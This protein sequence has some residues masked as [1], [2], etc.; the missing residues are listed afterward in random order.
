ML[1]SDGDGIYDTIEI[2]GVRIQ[3]GKVVY[4]DP[5]KADTDG[6]GVS[7]FD[8]LGGLPYN[9]IVQW[10]S[11]E[12]VSTI[13]YQSSN[14][15]IFELNTEE[16]ID[17]YK[18][19]NNFE[20]LPYAKDNYDE[21]FI[22]DTGKKNLRGESIYGLCNI[23][24]SNPNELM[25]IRADE[26]VTKV[27]IQELLMHNGKVDIMKDASNFLIRYVLKQ[28]ERNFYDSKEILRSSDIARDI[29][30]LDVYYLMLAAEK[31]LKKDQ[32]VIFSTI[33]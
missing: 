19:V 6:D 15:N 24:N 8:E 1:D 27:I 16:T 29:W 10:N 4:T 23:Y 11:E 17:G 12:F 30:A 20:Y 14:P 18:V 32:T 3:N 2:N 7:D 26:I 25:K 22:E 31:Y 13:N 9:F 5:Y 21:I 33:T 28:D